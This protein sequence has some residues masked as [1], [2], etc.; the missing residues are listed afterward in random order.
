MVGDGIDVTL[1][2]TL[3]ILLLLGPSLNSNCKLFPKF[4]LFAESAI[5][6]FVKLYESKNPK[7]IFTFPE[8]A[9]IVVLLFFTYRTYQ[10]R[11]PQYSELVASIRTW[12]LRLSTIY[13]LGCGF[14]SILPRG[15]IRRIV[16]VDHWISAVAIGRSVATIAELSFVAMWALILYE[17]AKHTQSKIALVAS[18]I[19]VPL[20]FVAEIFSWYACTTGNY[21]GTIFES[22]LHYLFP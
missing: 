3:V 7:L 11:L 5:L 17:I 12:Q 15:D 10:K 18:K 16:L 19:M 6:L 22:L 9:D 13:V 20:I 14:R 21:I 2:N 1:G 4:G 8:F